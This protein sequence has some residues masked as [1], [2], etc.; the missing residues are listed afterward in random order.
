[1]FPSTIQLEFNIRH[2]SIIAFYIAKYRP[3]ISL[4]GCVG[5]SAS[6]T[7]P[8]QYIYIKATSLNSAQAKGLLVGMRCIVLV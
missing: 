8:S 7:M 4:C 5:G 6:I 3:N 2:D 1:M